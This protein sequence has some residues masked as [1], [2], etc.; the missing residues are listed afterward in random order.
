[1]TVAPDSAAPAPA[2]LDRPRRQY[3][4]WMRGLAVL[5]MIEAHVIDSWT[6][7]ADRATK[8]AGWSQIIGGFGAPLFLFL[9]GVTV[10]LSAGAKLQRSGNVSEAWRAV[11]RRGAQI[12][13][14]AFLFRL[15]AL[16]LG[17][18]HPRT[19]LRVD[20]LN[21][22]G[23]SIVAAAALWGALRTNRVRCLAFGG[24][25]LAVPLVTPI[26]H[27]MDVFAPLPDPLEA[28]IRPTGS[29]NNFVLFPWCGFV[30]AGALLGLAF[31]AACRR[32]EEFRFA[33]RLAI[34]GTALGAASYALS[35]L[36]S[37]Y[38]SSY[39]WTTSPTFFFLRAGIMTAAVGLVMGWYARRDAPGRWS[40]V[41]QLGR[42]SLFIYWIHVEM[43]YGLASRPLRQ[44][45]SLTQAWI[46][47]AIFWVLMLACSIGKDRFVEWW[48]TRHADPNR[49]NRAP[50]YPV[51]ARIAA[52]GSTPAARRAGR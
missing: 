31:E 47:W 35:F 8:G 6:R 32:D 19:L 51:S 44:S 2:R 39:F 49:P 42:T 52:G 23:P 38:S 9:A 45:L 16:I 5:I 40:P 1:L 50:S 48:Q 14:L 11:A 24:V 3:L 33:T 26:V 30:F 21:I 28:Y 25:T 34:G 36:P 7:A 12:F 13:G 46:A 20:I 15:Q 18:G 43:V 41:E 22:M 29:L 27:A 10:A 37:P 4:D 17:W